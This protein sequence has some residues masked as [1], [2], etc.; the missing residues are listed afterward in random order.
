M[1]DQGEWLRQPDKNRGDKPGHQKSDR[2][3]RYAEKKKNEKKKR[4]D[5]GS[6]LIMYRDPEMLDVK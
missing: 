3:K 4:E 6:C 5:I 2:L 1:S